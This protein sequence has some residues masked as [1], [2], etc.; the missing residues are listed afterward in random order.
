M[1]RKKV[2]TADQ[3]PKADFVGKKSRAILMEVTS[4]KFD[5]A[6]G[7]KQDVMVL[8][9]GDNEY[10]TK[11]SDANMNWLI[12]HFGPND[13]NW[14]KQVLFFTCVPI[15]FVDRKTGENKG[16]YTIALSVE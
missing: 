15:A 10:Q 6:N 8:K 9:V 14:K 1:E 5:K 12:D 7:V 2:L 3:L 11:L 16:G 13:E 4:G